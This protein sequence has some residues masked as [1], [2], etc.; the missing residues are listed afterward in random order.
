M[1][2][3]NLAPMDVL[4]PLDPLTQELDD[5]GILYDKSTIADL[6]GMNAAPPGPI[7]DFLRAQL[8][9][10]IAEER[11]R[12]MIDVFPLAPSEH[13]SSGEIQL[14][15][16]NDG[17]RVAQFLDAFR[18]NIVLLGGTGGGKSTLG[19]QIA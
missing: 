19:T 13:V 11:E 7:Q 10:R 12:Q 6:H 1:R 16:Q 18:Y 5:L 17:S 3:R 8:Q 2:G 14:G 15:Q 4:H 9:E